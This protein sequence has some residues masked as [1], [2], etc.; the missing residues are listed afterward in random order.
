VQVQYIVYIV[1]INLHYKLFSKQFNN[2][3][4]CD[5]QEQGLIVKL[6]YNSIYRKDYTE[7]ITS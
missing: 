7:F 6:K 2:Y 4:Y 1:E 5:L 3:Q